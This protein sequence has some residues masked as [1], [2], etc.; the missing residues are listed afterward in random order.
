MKKYTKDF[1][2]PFCN[3]LEFEKV[4]KFSVDFKNVNW[5]DN[6]VYDINKEELYIC[7]M[8]GEKF[9]IE[10][11]QESME[12]IINKYKNDEWKEGE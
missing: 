4:F 3:G 2:C 6:I 7:R 8:C 1:S 5:T 9:T 12:R 10:Y 11:M